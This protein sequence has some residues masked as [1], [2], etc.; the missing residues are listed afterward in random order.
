MTRATN[1]RFGPGN[2]GKPAGARN[3]LQADFILALQKDFKENGPD[4][5]NIVRVER[6]ADYL[7]I[8][9]SILP[10]EMLLSASPLEE[11]SDDELANAIET[12]RQAGAVAKEKRN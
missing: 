2:S 1:G 9:A 12:L 5:I 7:K 6:P 8:L 11:M 3:K 4:V 10:K